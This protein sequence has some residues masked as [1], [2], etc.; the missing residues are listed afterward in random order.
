ML[1]HQYI[2]KETP[3][4]HFKICQKA[5]DRVQHILHKTFKNYVDQMIFF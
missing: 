5:F 1:Y 3:S 4:I 2:K